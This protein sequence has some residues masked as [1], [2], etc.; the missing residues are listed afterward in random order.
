MPLTPPAHVVIAIDGP[1]GA[2]KST[3]AKRLAQILGYRYVESGAL[4]RAVGWLVQTQAHVASDSPGLAE[5]LKHTAIEL[6]FADG[7]LAVWVDGTNVTARL[8]GETIGR[9]A[10]AVATQPVVRHVI[11]AKLR[12]LRC[13]TAL[14]V[15][16]RDIGTVVFPDATVKFFLDASL[17][18]RAQ[19]RLQE[20][21]RAGQYMQLEQIKQVVA[22]RDAQDR[23]RAMSPLARAPDAQVINTTDLTV[24]AVVESMLSGVHTKVPL[25]CP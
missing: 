19:R 17:E 8:R 13:Q 9:A 2:G 24:D 20:M 5:M 1:A 12:Q 14:V 7:Q 18:V 3:A 23:E 22:G 10:S 15:E 25:H 4:Y 6:T 11:T 21:Q 16:G